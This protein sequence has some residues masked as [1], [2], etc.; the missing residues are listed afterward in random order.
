[1]ILYHGSNTAVKNIDLN[2][3]RP[4]KDFGR[5]FYLTDIREQAK[6]MAYRTARIYGGEACVSIFDLDEKIFDDNVIKRLIFSEAN[7]DW[8]MFVMNNR[9][10]SDKNNAD[11]LCNKDNKYDMVFGPVAD[12]NIAYLFRNFENGFINT[13][14]L[15]NG[16]KYKMLSTQFS[17]HTEK[18]IQYLTY[19]EVSNG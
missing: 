19:M 18:S 14:M 4:N 1:V 6:Q 8:A 13:E 3:C 5:G 2:K 12:D 9:G 10:F 15:T 11:P 17:F 7:N 16:L